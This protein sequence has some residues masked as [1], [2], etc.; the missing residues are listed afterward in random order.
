[1]Y[2]SEKVGTLWMDVACVNSLQRCGTPTIKTTERDI[3]PQ[4]AAF[5][6]LQKTSGRYSTIYAPLSRDLNRRLTGCEQRKIIRQALPS[7][8][9]YGPAWS[10]REAVNWF[11]SPGERGYRSLVRFNNE[12]YHGL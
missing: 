8:S 12:I 2:H 9:F 7:Q 10:S 5:T 6:G 11:S 3:T 4:F 1:M